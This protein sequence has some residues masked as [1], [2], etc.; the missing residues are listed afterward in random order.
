MHPTADRRPGDGRMVSIVE[1]A[2]GVIERDGAHGLRM[3][4]VAKEA[5][6]SKALVHYYFSTRQELLRAA[7][8]WAERRW[9][10]AVAERVSRFATGADQVEA[11]LL[12]S[13]GPEAPFGSQRALWND[14]WSGLQLD[15]E[16]RPLVEAS[17]RAWVERLGKLITGGLKDGSIPGSVKADPAAWR[18]AALGDGLDSMLYLGLITPKRARSLARVAVARELA[19]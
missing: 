4:T 16:L 13:I 11:A 1:A 18:L 7:F 8:D 5:G 12:A 15:D 2:L 9:Q 3:A 6:V 10:D 19:A 17:Y 14:V